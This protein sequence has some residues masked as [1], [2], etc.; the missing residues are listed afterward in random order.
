MRSDVD[1]NIIVCSLSGL[2]TPVL[3]VDVLQFW[4]SWVCVGVCMD[5]YVSRSQRA[6]RR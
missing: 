3:A 1:E 4:F 2:P 5:Y 6:F